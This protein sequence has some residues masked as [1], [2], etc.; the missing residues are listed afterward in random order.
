[1]S[2]K[3]ILAWDHMQIHKLTNTHYACT[4]SWTK[5][6]QEIHIHIHLETPRTLPVSYQSEYR[7]CSEI[8]GAQSCPQEPN[9]WP[10]KGCYD[11]T[12]PPPPPL[13]PLLTALFFY[14]TGN[15]IDSTALKPFLQLS[16]GDCGPRTSLMQPPSPR[17][18]NW[19]HLWKNRRG[20]RKRGGERGKMSAWGVCVE[21]GQ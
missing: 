5:C 6:H 10:P 4:L 18:V 12:H 16:D 9:L 14:H 7:A 15:Q 21:R 3:V 17:L 11:D 20:D 19:S 2:A 13:L 1:M 8:R